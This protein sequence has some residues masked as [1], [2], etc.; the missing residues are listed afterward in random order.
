M[1]I[2]TEVNAILNKKMDRQDF[3]KHVA[4]GIVAL[5]GA[6]SALRLL[7]PKQNTSVSSGYGGSAYGGIK[8]GK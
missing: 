7:A 2:K 6:G 8:E 5:T 1:A 4:I 3:I